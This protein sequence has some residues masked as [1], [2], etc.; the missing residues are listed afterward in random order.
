MWQNIHIWGLNLLLTEEFLNQKNLIK[1]AEIFLGLNK[2]LIATKETRLDSSHF[3]VLGLLLKHLFPRLDSL[4]TNAKSNFL[5]EI[6]YFN[7]TFP[8]G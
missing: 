5:K 4:F 7:Y 8:K 1:N 3:I 6:I 2:R